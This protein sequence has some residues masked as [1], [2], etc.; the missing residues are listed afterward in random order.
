[1]DL[2]GRFRVGERI[3]TVLAGIFTVLF[4]G[5]VLQRFLPPEDLNETAPSFRQDLPDEYLYTG[6]NV[7]AEEVDLTIIYLD[8]LIAVNWLI[9]FLLV[10]ACARLLR[11]EG[12]IGRQVLGSL[13]GG[14]SAV[15]ILLPPMGAWISL[16]VQ[17]V[18]AA[19]MALIT[20]PWQGMRAYIKQTGL[21]FVVSALFAGVALALFT[22]AAPS[23]LYVANGT[24][25]YYI[26]PLWLAVLCAVGYGVV[27]LCERLF[28][29]SRPQGGIYKLSVTDAGGTVVISALYDSGNRLCETFSGAPV[30]VAEREAVMEVLSPAMKR[31]LKALEE[32]GVP[33]EQ[34]VVP[35]WR[36]VPFKS[37]GGNGLLPAFKPQSLQ[38]QN[39]TGETCSVTGCYLALGRSLGRG[40]YRALLGDGVVTALKEKKKGERYEMVT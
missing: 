40:E 1:M 23:G 10:R 22:F 8:I 20:F 4:M 30:I 13:F 31:L 27:V 35:G 19:V 21:L 2:L 28:R 33:G 24:V 36:L 9:D 15:A 12:K 37:I 39:E 38:L 26:P 34:S 16:W 18:T 7:V 32:N 5:M 25:Y 14:C 11:C 17:L 29:H 6:N 3:L